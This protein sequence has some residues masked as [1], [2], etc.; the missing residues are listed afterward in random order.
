MDTCEGHASKPVP[1]NE[2]KWNRV[3][4]RATWTRNVFSETKPARR[5]RGCVHRHVF[6]P[7]AENTGRSFVNAQLGV[8]ESF[9]STA[10]FFSSAVM[11]WLLW[12]R[13]FMGKMYCKLSGFQTV[14]CALL[15][16]HRQPVEQYQ[17]EWLGF[18]SLV[19]ILNLT[20]TSTVNKMFFQAINFISV[21]VVWA[22][23]F[24]KDTNAWIAAELNSALLFF[25]T[26][27]VF[28]L[29][30]SYTVIGWLGK[31]QPHCWQSW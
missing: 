4:S 28:H 2:W 13:I 8:F 7:P 21:L 24:G 27:L 14:G 31:Q 26:W 30:S 1:Y 29:V 6:S 5:Q 25:S 10:F 12:Y 9:E 19:D 17:F 11:L 23:S 3:L 20:G 22:I 15:V 16:G 18:L